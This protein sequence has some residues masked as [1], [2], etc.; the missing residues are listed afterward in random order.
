MFD[1]DRVARQLATQELAQRQH[2][3]FAGLLGGQASYYGQALQPSPQQPK[4]D[5][6][7]LLLEDV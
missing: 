7:L 2:Q 1:Y 3:G 6:K 5:S 4:D